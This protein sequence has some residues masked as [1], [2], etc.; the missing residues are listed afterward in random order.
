MEAYQ[1]RHSPV[2]AADHDGHVLRIRKAFPVRDELTLIFGIQ[3]DTGTAHTQ[4]LSAPHCRIVLDVTNGH[5][6]MLGTGQRR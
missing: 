4:E 6:Q 5:L 3:R 1:Y 2:G